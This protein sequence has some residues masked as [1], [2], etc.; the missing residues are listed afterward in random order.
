MRETRKGITK[1]TLKYADG[2][3]D[4]AD[5]RV[6][7]VVDCLEAILDVAAGLGREDKQEI[8]NIFNREHRTNQ[9]AFIREVVM[10]ILEALA[11]NAKPGYHD[12]RNEGAV[13][14]AVAALAAQEEARIGLPLV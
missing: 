3:I 13:A 6:A 10:T 5:A 4:E 11:E 2:K 14:F 7:T 12:L 1:T 8:K 9:Q